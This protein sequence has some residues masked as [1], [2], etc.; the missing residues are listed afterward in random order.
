M[1]K[2]QSKVDIIFSPALLR[3]RYFMFEFYT[4]I[5][6]VKHPRQTPE[7]DKFQCLNKRIYGNRWK[8]FAFRRVIFT[9][10]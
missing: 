6:E 5:S 3:G 9:N 8:S 4:Y 10:V 1:V 7:K 2:T